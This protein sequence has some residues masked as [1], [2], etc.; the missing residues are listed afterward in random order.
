MIKHFCDLCKKEMKYSDSFIIYLRDVEGSNHG[1]FDVC[2]RCF[3]EVS[4]ALSAIP[5]RDTPC[6]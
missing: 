6:L 1:D 3:S 5:K 4:A 2:Q